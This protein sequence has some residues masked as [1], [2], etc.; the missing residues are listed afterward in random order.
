[1][2]LLLRTLNCIGRQAAAQGQ[3]VA[4]IEVSR[5]V[6]TPILLVSSHGA[7]AKPAASRLDQYS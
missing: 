4:E 5:L 1:M 2:P 3:G 7:A 6:L